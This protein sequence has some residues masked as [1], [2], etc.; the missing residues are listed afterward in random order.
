MTER[1]SPVLQGTIGCYYAAPFRCMAIQKDFKQIIRRL[2]RNTLAQEQV[3][4]NQK[5]GFGKELAFSFVWVD[6]IQ[7]DLQRRHDLHDRRSRS[8]FESRHEP[9]S[10]Q[11][12][13]CLCQTKQSHNALL[14]ETVTVYCR[15]HPLHGQSL[16]VHKRKRDRTGEYVFCLLHDDT[17]CLIPT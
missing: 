16:R 11:H 3:A 9:R 13:S 6:G 8:R 5:I 1:F 12:D 10:W 7:G 15:W 17:L 14:Y 2:F 4:N